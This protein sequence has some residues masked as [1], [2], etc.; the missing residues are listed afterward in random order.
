MLMGAVTLRNAVRVVAPFLYAL[1]L[2]SVLVGTISV[3]TFAERRLG[4]WNDKPGIQLADLTAL[5][6][7][8]DLLVVTTILL[9]GG[10][11]FGALALALPRVER[12]A[13][14]TVLD[15]LRH[16]ALL[17]ALLCGL[18]FLLTVSYANQAA[19][20]ISL[21]YGAAVVVFL[22]AGYATL[23]DALVW[24]WSRRRFPPT[25]SGD[26]A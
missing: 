6:Y 23:I 3:V 1:G 16:C 10:T 8:G 15:H 18:V 11:V 24:V 22:T 17:Y 26:T 21:G 13:A 14:P 20:G 2:F 7:N 19:H 9:L 12:L 25:S 5:S 4:F